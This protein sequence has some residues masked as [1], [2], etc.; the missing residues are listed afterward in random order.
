MAEND[1]VGGQKNVTSSK[2]LK[3]LKAQM[4]QEAI[5]SDLDVIHGR[6]PEPPGARASHPQLAPPPTARRR[7]EAFAVAVVMA[8]AAVAG[9]RVSARAVPETPVAALPRTADSSL[10][11]APIALPDPSLLSQ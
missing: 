5:N 2:S 3:H 4:L 11:P 8:S 7:L 9:W 10:A 6:L 1:G